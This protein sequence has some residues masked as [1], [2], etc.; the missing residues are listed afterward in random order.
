MS[1]Y[2]GTGADF[3]LGNPEEDRIKRRNEWFLALVRETQ[4]D[5][6]SWIISSPGNDTVTLETLQTSTFP[7][8]LKR[9]G[10]PLVEIEPGERILHMAHHQPLEIS[11]SGALVSAA[12]GSTKPV[13]I[14]IHG[15]GRHPTRRYTFRAP[16]FIAGR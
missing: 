13:T 6:T 4:I 2:L 12:I 16:R 11:S 15:A 5:G 14:I 7:D 10:Y 1:P 3:K 9:R 8:E